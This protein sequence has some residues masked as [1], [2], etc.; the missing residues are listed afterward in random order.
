MYLLRLV[1]EFKIVKVL[2][3][4]VLLMSFFFITFSAVSGDEFDNV[5]AVIREEMR[6]VSAASV[7]VA[8]VK[9]GEIVW[10]EGFGWADR[11]NRIP[12]TEHTMY[13]LASISK[14][15]AATAIMKLVQ[16]GKIDLDA[17][18][19]DYLGTAKL[20]AHVGDV[21]DATV[22]RVANHTAGL[23]VYE[24]FFY[25]EEELRLLPTMDHI[26][27]RYGMIVNEPGAEYRYN[28]FGYGLLDHV[29][30]HVSGKPFAEYMREEIFTPLGMNRS[31]IN[32]GAGLE[33]HVAK[34]YN[35]DG[36]LIPYYE[37]DSPG[38]AAMYSSAHDLVRF[39]Q[40]W[41]GNLRPDQ[42][43]ILKK[44]TREM[45]APVEG[46][47][48]YGIGLIYEKIGGYDTVNHSGSMSGVY[49][50]LTMVPSEEAV[51]VVLAN[52]TP[53][54][55]MIS[56]KIL[57][58]ILPKWQV[59]EPKDTG[60][61]QLAPN[62]GTPSSIAGDWEGVIQTYERDIP[63]RLK[64][65]VDGEVH[66]KVDDQLWALVNDVSFED[67]GIN[68]ESLSYID[69]SDTQRNKHKTNFKLKLR[70]GSL[71][72]VAM[73]STGFPGRAGAYSDYWLYALSHWMVLKRLETPVS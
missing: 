62:I 7:S 43:E 12:A 9:K 3:Y 60:D 4:F 51:V 49:T 29:I 65:R 19:N 42:K 6:E 45:M 26:I 57:Q 53:D 52:G 59:A 58:T 47:E 11:E 28:N 2:Q 63:V 44:E 68:G 48:G 34:R 35:F 27:S 14:S 72:G 30:S 1:A 46:P 18:I 23:A 20:I 69:T 13:S 37:I 67:G 31:S 21:N 64:V 33:P 56:E 24:Q 70:D 40:F 32:I 8:V 66:V 25:G 61:E 5:R 10:Q 16:E 39:G 38:A 73:A 41:N 17:P 15:F 50:L 55:H 71:S 36:Q 54:I 22:R